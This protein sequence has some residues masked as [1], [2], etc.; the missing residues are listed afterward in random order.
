MTT[1][2]HITQ[3][4]LVISYAL[5]IAVTARAGSDPFTPVPEKDVTLKKLKTI[6]TTAFFKAEFDEDGDLK[7]EDSGMKIFVKMD[8]EKKLITFFTAVPL[9]QSVTEIKKLQLVNRLNNDLIFVRF[10]MPR[11]NTLWCDYDLSYEGGITPFAIINTY[12]LFAKVVGGAIL[13]QDP[14]DIIGAE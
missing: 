13:T 7:L 10:C 11:P 3:F 4:L 6:F 2:K 9:K 5:C 1:Y 12:R 8:T 14:E